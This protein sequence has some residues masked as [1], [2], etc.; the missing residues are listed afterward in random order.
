MRSLQDYKEIIEDSVYGIPQRLKDYDPSF[1]VV[2]NHKTGKFEIHSTDNMFDSYCFTVHFDELDQRT[3]DIVM[4]NDMNKK[5]ARDLEREVD[6]HN[7]K[8]EKAQKRDFHNWAESVAKET[9]S[10]WKKDIDNEY[11]GMPKKVT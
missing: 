11:I 7:E 1:F 2:R 4:K 5:S 6:E 3:L 9:Y 8:I 10:H